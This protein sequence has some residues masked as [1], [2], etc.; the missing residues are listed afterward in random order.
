MEKYD[1]AE[2]EDDEDD[3][4]VCDAVTTSDECGCTDNVTSCG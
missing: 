3:D 1:E 4:S 2:E